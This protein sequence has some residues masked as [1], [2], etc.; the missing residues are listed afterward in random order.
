MKTKIIIKRIILCLTIMLVMLIPNFNYS[1]EKVLLG[2]INKNDKVDSIDLLYMMRHIVA[3]NGGIHKEWILKD[4]KYKLADVT[5]NG[6]VNS[7]D[8]LVILRYI[9]A[10][11]NPEE[12]GKKHKE[13]LKLKESEISKTEVENEIVE[14]NTANEEN[15]IVDNNEI[16]DESNVE[17]KAIKLNKSVID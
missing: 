16:I 4:D 10:N 17:V 15:N 13:W 1:V 11:N 2:D 6:I 12:I 5:Q 14:T 9:A 7:S 3:E 8:M